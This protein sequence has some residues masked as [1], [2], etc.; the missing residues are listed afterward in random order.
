MEREEEENIRSSRDKS[1]LIALF[2][3]PTLGAFSTRFLV[4]ETQKSQADSVFARLRADWARTA[5][6]ASDE[7]A[8]AVRRQ[9]MRNRNEGISGVN[10]GGPSAIPLVKGY[11]GIADAGLIEPGEGVWVDPSARNAASVLAKAGLRDGPTMSASLFLSPAR[12]TDPTQELLG[13]L[14]GIP[15]ALGAGASPFGAGNARPQSSLFRRGLLALAA[16]GDKPEEDLARARRLSADAVPPLC[17]TYGDCR[18]EPSAI[19]AQWGFDGNFTWKKAPGRPP[20]PRLDGSGTP[21]VPNN[22]DGFSPGRD[23]AG[24]VLAERRLCAQAAQRYAANEAEVENE[25]AAAQS[26]ADW[27]EEKS[28]CLKLADLRCAAQ[29]ECPLTASTPCGA[30]A[31]G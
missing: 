30:P 22:G 21:S 17:R 15:G 23:P 26:S 24:S 8:R 19:L 29:R 13:K 9:A 11:R 10:T 3:L 27:G 2:L 6:A 7:E 31:C 12:A 28:L 1:F 5:R 18:P 14:P 16:Y 4:S 25:L 20:A